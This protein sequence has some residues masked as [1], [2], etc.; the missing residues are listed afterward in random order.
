MDLPL[1]LKKNKK[2]T[3]NF[4]VSIRPSQNMWM[5]KCAVEW[6]DMHLSVKSVVLFGGMLETI[7]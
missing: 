6:N 7:F 5:L 2:K 4:Q 1:V 3:W